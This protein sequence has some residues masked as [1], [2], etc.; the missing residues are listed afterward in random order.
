M[1]RIIRL[2]FSHLYNSK[3][4]VV[5]VIMISMMTILSGCSSPLVGQNKGPAEIK[6][7]VCM[8]N[9]YEPFVWSIA[10]NM[11]AWCREKEKETGIKFT[12]DIVSSKGSQLTQNDQ[13]EKFIAEGYDVL[14]INLV[15]RTDPT[16]IIE[17]AMDA[18]IPIVFFNRELVEE[19]LDRWDKLYYVGAEA[20]QAGMIQAQI[21]ID[22]LADEEKFDEID[23]NHNGTIQYIM[24]EGEP[25]H[26][27]A[28]IRTRVCTEEL[29]NAGISIEKLG[30]ENANWDRDQAKTKM[31]DL[32]KRFPFQIEMIIANDDVMAL[33]AIDAL[34]E[35]NYPNKPLVVGV[36]GNPEALEAIHS[37]KMIGSAY[38]DAVKKADT[39]MTVA[40]CL[41]TE[42]EFPEDISMHDG[43]SVY[44]PYSQITYE[45]VFEYMDTK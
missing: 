11:S 34:E 32:I 14:C 28:L 31:R 19:D 38:N 3:I 1:K 7:G 24:L 30:D 22:T 43:K 29:Q 40:Y 42:S 23:V 17:R 9:A 44:L 6:I 18:D 10:D 21:I 13:V 26:Q 25:G 39:I 35:A 36:N 20:E 16:V 12:I 33:G 45:N 15:D 4:A 27:D 41:A 5:L 8:H 37:G 2:F